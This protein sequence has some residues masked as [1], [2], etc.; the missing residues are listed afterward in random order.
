[1]KSREYIISTPVK[2][3]MAIEYLDTY[4]YDWELTDSDYYAKLLSKEVERVLGIPLEG[5]FLTPI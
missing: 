5:Y 1:M 3:G 2:V 4:F